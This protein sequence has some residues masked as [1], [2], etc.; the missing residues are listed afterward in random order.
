MNPS[1]SHFRARAKAVFWICLMALVPGLSW[2]QDQLRSEQELI[3]LQSKILDLQAMLDADREA[4][5]DLETE[6]IGIEKQQLGLVLER[7]GLNLELAVLNAARIDLENR[8]SELETQ[9][10]EALESLEEIIR[11]RFVL[12]RQEA[13]RYLLDGSAPEKKSISLAIYRYL[14]EEQ[15]REF[16]NL[17]S[18]EAQAETNISEVQDNQQEID[19]MLARVDG[20][21]R[22]LEAIGQLRQ[23]RL[24]EVRTALGAGER[25]LDLFVKKE[26]EIELLLQNLRQQEEQKNIANQGLTD[27]DL[28]Q[29][30]F[31]RQQ[32]KLPKPLNTNIMVAFGEKRVESGLAQDGILFDAKDGDAIRAVYNGEV[33]YSDWFYGYGQLLVLDHGENYMSLYAHNEQLKVMLGDWVQT[34]DTIAFA[35]TTGGVSEPALYFEIRADGSPDD[36]EKWFQE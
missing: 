2:S 34:G 9:R 7:D 3:E 4:E 31:A 29:R 5:Q 28:E 11:A 12:G 26:S 35:G 23:T 16:E 24:N 15:V 20:K 30:A 1:I 14:I 21:E 19:I 27:E 6:I 36:P 17:K 13:M 8:K 32:G 33:V 18:I 22:E 25:Q 10:V